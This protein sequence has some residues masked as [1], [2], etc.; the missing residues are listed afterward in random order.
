M[1]FSKLTTRQGMRAILDRLNS[2]PLVGCQSS[3]LPS[4]SG[5]SLSGAPDR[6]FGGPIISPPTISGMSAPALRAWRRDR[7]QARE[8][9]IRPTLD[10]KSE[11]SS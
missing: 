4:A 5:G 2:Q 9:L 7:Q 1:I 3:K 8:Q 11:R 6:T 10:A